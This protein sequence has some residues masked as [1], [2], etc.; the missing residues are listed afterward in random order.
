MHMSYFG[1]CTFHSSFKDA[2][3]TNL[4]M[5]EVLIHVNFHVS[6]DMQ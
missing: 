3:I 5:L 2:L 6:D 4:R 1:D